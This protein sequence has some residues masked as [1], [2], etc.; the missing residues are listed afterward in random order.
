MQFRRNVGTLDR[1]LRLGL[2]VTFLYLGFFDNS[3]FIRD[4]LAAT[5]LGSMGIMLVVIAAIAWCPFY[6][7]IG[8]NSIGEKA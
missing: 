5:L 8:F 3:S 4:A 2:G 1:T 7:L 6:H